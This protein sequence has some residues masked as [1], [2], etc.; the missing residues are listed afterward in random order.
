[1]P[2]NQ[3]IKQLLAAVSLNDDQSAYRELFILLHKR[4]K[5]FSF[6]IIRS[7]EEA[8]EIVSDLFIR[9][10]QKRKQLSHI[11]SPLLYFYTAIK[12]QS[13]NQLD[14]N[15]RKHNLSAEAWLVQTDSF[16]FNPEQLLLT[17]EMMR[18]IKKAVNELPP[19]CRLVFKLVKED[20]LT[21]N[22]TASLLHLSIKTIEA[23]MAI[24]LRRMA[25]CMQVEIKKPAS[26]S[27]A[28]LKK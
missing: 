15:K 8:E 23:Q 16:Y 5:Q 3:D 27:L 14:K 28:T 1:M 11:H 10:W 19:R 2:G 17:G 20:G 9:I 12:N 25:R 4:L 7:V 6:S 18:Q 21:Y 24:A 22:E 13:L 26:F